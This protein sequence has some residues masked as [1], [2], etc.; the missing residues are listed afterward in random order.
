MQKKS[1]FETLSPRTSRQGDNNII[2]K[3]KVE[4]KSPVLTASSGFISKLKSTEVQ[5]NKYLGQYKDLVE[6]VRTEERFKQFID[7]IIDIGIVALDTETT[8]LNVIDDTI[9][10]FSMYAPGEKAI[11]VPMRHISYVTK[12]ILQNQLSEK[13][14]NEQLSRLKDTKVIYHNADFDYRIIKW[15]YNVDLPVYWDTLL[16]AKCLNNLEEAKLKSQYVFHIDPTAKAYSFKEFFT[17]EEFPMVPVDMAALY[18]GIDAYKTYILYEWQNKELDKYPRIR[19]AFMDLEMSLVKA[20]AYM[21]DTGVELDADYT[22]QLSVKYNDMRQKAQKAADEEVAQYKSKILAANKKGL[23]INYPMNLSSPTQLAILLYDVLKIEPVDKKSPRGTG[24]EILKKID[25]PLCK[26]ILELRGLDKLIGTYIDKLPK[27]VNSK[28]NRIHA[29]FNQY[30]TD[31]GRFSSNSPN[32]QNIP[33]HNLDIRKMFKA[34]DGYYMCS[35]D[36]SKQEPYTLAEF[37][38]DEKFIEVFKSGKDVYSMIASDVYHV[39]YEECLEFNPD[40]TTNKKGKERRS[41]AKSILLGLMY[42]RGANSIAEQTQSTLEEAQKIIDGFYKS[43]KTTKRWMDKT[44]SDAAINGWVETLYGHRRQLP[45]MKL[46]KYEF[47]YTTSKPKDF[48]PLTFGQIS[49]VS[50]EVEQDKVNYYTNKLDRCKGFK[51]RQEIKEAAKQ[52]GIIIKENELK[53]ADATRQCVNSRIQGS[54]AEMTKLAMINIYNNNRLKELGFRLLIQVHDEVIG[55]CPKENAKEAFDLVSKI[56]IQSAKKFI[57]FPMKCDVTVTDRWYG[58]E[59][60]IS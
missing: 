25:L 53:L 58:D 42:G 57:S 36:Y 59:I 41:N 46:P 43:Y 5:I 52:E 1:L 7:N 8:G 11:Y 3:S 23:K 28:T 2:K 35:I 10:S 40:H 22:K 14:V 4:L 55:E 30:G 29:R 18:A 20:V 13:F 48:N 24:E 27:E 34:T 51:Q 44:V 19:K 26:K 45:D 38:K 32:L 54:A 50:D 12:E 21:E 16:C 9:V 49:T 60:E 37:S 33:S 15:H 17:T 6:T 56:M 47:R 39:P 31:T